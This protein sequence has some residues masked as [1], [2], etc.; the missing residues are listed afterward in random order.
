MS[1][2]YSWQDFPSHL[3]E[4]AINFIGNRF[5]IFDSMIYEFARLS[6]LSFD[7]SSLLLSLLNER[8]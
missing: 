6:G 3:Q 2:Y 7:K 4:L 1:E 5:Y 8:N